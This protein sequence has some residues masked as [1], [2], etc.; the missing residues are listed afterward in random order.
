MKQKILADLHT[1]LNE[2]KIKP[3]EWW[4]A[5]KKK[6]LSIIAITE[7]SEYNPESAYRKLVETKPLGIILIPGIE[8]NTSVGHLLIYGKDDSIYKVKELQKIGVNIELALKLVKKHGF[9]ASFSHPYGWKT[10]SV[11][12]IIGENKAKKIIKKY[13]VGIEYY[14]GMLGTANGF[15]LDE[16]WVKKFYNFFEFTEKTRPAKLFLLSKPS[17]K[18]K[19]KIIK[20]TVET[21]ERVRQ[22]MVFS[23]NAK[24]ITAGS[25]AHYP[26]NIG[27]AIIELKKMPKNEKE[28]ISMLKNKEVVYA[29]PNIYSKEPIDM[30]KKK[31]MLLG[32]KYIA[33]RKLKQQKVIKKITKRIKN[34]KIVKKMASKKLFN[35]IKPRNIVVKSKQMILRVKNFP[36]KIKRRGA[37]K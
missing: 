28:F 35:Q 25:D 23:E 21:F 17:A 9:L 5:V 36:K 14:N 12:L 7:H 22:G 31:E 19:E 30:L 1:H 2:K 11:C 15:L 8:A 6:K 27:G 10:D 3:K 32:I 37:I 16:M 33:Q 24:F 29:G 4:G 18:I 13:G 20:L 26:K 34:Q